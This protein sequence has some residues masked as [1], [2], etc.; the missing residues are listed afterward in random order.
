M[1]TLTSIKV[2]RQVVESGSF[3]AA[4]GRLRI[5]TAMVSRHVMHVEKR[6]G[7][8]LLNRNSRTLSLTE[9]GRAYFERS[10]T[11][12]DDLEDTEMELG[13]LSS[14]PRG[15]LRLSCPSWI[16]GQ[17]L[18][19]H[20][21][22]FRRRYPEV[23]VDVSFDDRTVDLVDEGYD[24]ALW[25]TS[26]DSLSPGLLAQPVRPVSYFLAASAGYLERHGVPKSLEELARHNF[27][28]IG[29]QNS[30]Q[31]VGPSGKLELPMRVVLRYRS[32]LGLAN[33]VASGIGLAPLPAV[34]FEDPEFRTQLTP[35]LMEYPLSQ[36]MLNLVYVNRR[37]VPLKI[38]AFRDF[39]VER[40]SNAPEPNP[41]R[42][43]ITQ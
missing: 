10:K 39:I 16:T 25:L 20:F 37:Y 30:L 14:T 3:V 29:D 15:T 6:L 21:A 2:F 34:M 41:L 27:V 8:R 17:R 26:S 1:D 4:G 23:I 36:H 18:V 33:A 5:S 9:V 12:L 11:I 7:L 43:S 40:I 31:F 35:I 38:R 19:Q 28:A 24:A 22:E 32:P 13:S 42:L